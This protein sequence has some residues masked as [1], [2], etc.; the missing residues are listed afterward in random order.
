V[1]AAVYTCG[2]IV[3]IPYIDYIIIESKYKTLYKCT[4]FSIKLLRRQYSVVGVG[5]SIAGGCLRGFVIGNLDFN[6]GAEVTAD[7]FAAGGTRLRTTTS[8]AR[9][10]NHCG[11]PVN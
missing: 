7:N 10:G 8:H 9:V 5:G 2:S 4:K 3:S 11:T 6:L 1:K